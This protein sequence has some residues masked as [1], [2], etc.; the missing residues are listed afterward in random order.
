[1]ASSLGLL[2]CEFTIEA[3]SGSTVGLLRPEGWCSQLLIFIVKHIALYANWT[4]DAIAFV[5]ELYMQPQAFLFS[6]I[7]LDK[8]L[9]SFLAGL[10]LLVDFRKIKILHP[11]GFVRELQRLNELTF[12]RIDQ[13]VVLDH[14]LKS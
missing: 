12:G 5:R 11:K 3:A 9:C 7:E 2:L 1:M 8:T 6:N 10:Q 4:D 13:E 14:S